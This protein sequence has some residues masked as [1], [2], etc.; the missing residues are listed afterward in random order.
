MFLKRKF[1]VGYNLTMLKSGHEPNALVLPYFWYRLGPEV[2]KLT[3]V[4]SEI[5]LQIPTKYA[6]KFKTFFASFDEDL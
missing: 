5:T 3:E 1:G 2:K 6:S 4:Q